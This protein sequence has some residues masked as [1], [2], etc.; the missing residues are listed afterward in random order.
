MRDELLRAFLEANGRD[1]AP[2]AAQLWRVVKDLDSYVKP[3]GGE[4]DELRKRRIERVAGKV[5]KRAS[6]GKRGGTGSGRTRAGRRS[7]A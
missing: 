2:L 3:E 5:S 6:G 4:I 1:K 7:S